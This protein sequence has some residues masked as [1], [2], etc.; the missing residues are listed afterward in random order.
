MTSKTIS[1]AVPISSSS[2]LPEPTSSLVA[3][4]E[5]SSEDSDGTSDDSD[6]TS[7]V[8]RRHR[9]PPKRIAFPKVII[10]A[11]TETGQGESSIKVPL[12]RFYKGRRPVIP[13]SLADTPCATLGTQGVLDGLNETLR[14]TYTLDILSLRSILED[15][16]E[17][18]YDFGTAYGR[19]RQIWY[20]DDWSNIRDELRRWEE[21]DREMRREALP[22][23]HAWVDQKDCE[24]VWTPINGK[25]WPVPTPKD[26][27]LDLIRIEML[28]LGLQYMWLDILC[29]RQMGGPKEDLHAME[30]KLDMPT[31]GYVYEGVRVVIYLSG[32]G[33]PVSVKE[34]DLDGDRCWFRH[35][36][37]LQEVGDERI[38]AGDT[39]DG[40]IHD[41]PIDEGGNYK[42]ELLTRFHKQLLGLGWNDWDLFNRLADMRNRVS[43]NPMDKVAGLAFPLGPGTIPAYHETECYDFSIL[44]YLISILSHLITDISGSTGPTGPVSTPITNDFRYCATARDDRSPSSLFSLFLRIVTECST[45]IHI[46]I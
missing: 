12:Q 6:T 8:F 10:S 23:S 40:P 42:T 33:L 41:K 25:E 44:S 37:T 24:D 38:F 46:Y 45:R 1:E 17:K 34:G 31:I 18:H 29:L 5:S 9:W 19:L 28:N 2:L 16:I 43:T 7:Y 36:W 22:I 30:W 15:C 4:S 13:S 20:T 27:S 26:T 21:N 3:D 35:A 14:T 39:S 32:L 11:F